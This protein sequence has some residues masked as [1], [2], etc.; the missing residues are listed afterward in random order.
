MVDLEKEYCAHFKKK[1]Q[2]KTKG[3]MKLK[4]QVGKSAEL[5]A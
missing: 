3:S 5:R 2:E 4:E 1:R